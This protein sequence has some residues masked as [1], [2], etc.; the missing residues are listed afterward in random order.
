MRDWLYL[1]H[2]KMQHN[3]ERAAA[4]TSGWIDVEVRMPADGVVVQVKKTDGTTTAGKFDGVKWK[5]MLPGGADGTVIAWQPL[6][7]A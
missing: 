1:L 6:A 7:S 4:A 2:Q 5:W 3:S